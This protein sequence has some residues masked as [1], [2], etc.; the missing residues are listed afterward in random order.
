MSA[1]LGGNA[2]L[3]QA[4]GG[5]TSIKLDGKLWV[6]ASGKWLIH[7]ASEEMFLPIPLADILRSIER[8]EEYTTEHTTSDGITLRPSVETTMHA[9]IP[10]PCVV[11][12]HSVNTL[13]WA[14]LASS[15]Q[16][17]ADRLEGI[18]WEWIPYVH[19]G[20]PLAQRIKGSL[21]TRPDVLIMQNH[22]LIVGGDTCESAEALLY[23]VERRIHLTMRSAP[24]PDLPRLR[25]ISDENWVPAEDLE[26]HGLATDPV[27]CRIASEGTMYPDHCVYLGHA[28]AVK[29]A[30]ETPAEAAERYETR[31]GRTPAVLL[32]EGVGVLT[33][34]GLSR[35][36]REMLTC[37]SRVVRRIPENEPVHYLEYDQVARLMNWD[38]EHYRQAIARQME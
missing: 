3:I 9:A 8:N 12:V 6:K 18:R 2:D 15:P 37:L 28:V 29:H 38:A 27:S 4:G 26:A 36:G 30:A 5:N 31:W 19:P 33:S 16:S 13:A 22:G 17:F 7:A 24:A 14:A 35:A 32:C 23:E 11:H 21:A 1:R 10:H 25:S 20:L 34:A